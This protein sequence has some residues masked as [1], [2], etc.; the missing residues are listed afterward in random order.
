MGGLRGVCWGGGPAGAHPAPPIAA[1]DRS[2]KA[3]TLA[4]TAGKVVII[5]LWATWCGPCK[6]EMPS[7]ERLAARHRGQVVVIA[8]AND[9]GGWPAIDRFWGRN[10]PHL[11]PVLASGPELGEAL[12]VLGL[13]YTLV[14]GRDGREIARLPKAAEWD[15]GEPAR[16]VAAAVAAR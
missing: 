8:V 2:G 5:N 3:A 14:L 10:F 11:R 13:P 9:D 16:L 4:G 15:Q 1:R 7:L 6:A 12:G